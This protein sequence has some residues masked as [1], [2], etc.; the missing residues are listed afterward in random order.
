MSA[1]RENRKRRNERIQ[2]GL[3][4]LVMFSLVA[5]GVV[6]Y[7]MY[8]QR[9]AAEAVIYERNE[10][11]ESVPVYAE[12]PSDL[13]GLGDSELAFRS[14][15]AA[16]DDWQV[17]EDGTVIYQ[18]KH[19]RRASF[20]KATLAVGVDRKDG[21][22]TGNDPL[23]SGQ[24]DVDMIIAQDTAHNRIRILMIPRNAIVSMRVSDD[25]GI[26][27]EGTAYDQ[28]C[29][30]YA[31]GD[32]GET[33]VQNTLDAVTWTLCGTKLDYYAFTDMGILGRVNDAVGGVTVTIPN[34]ELVKANPEW[35]KGRTVTLMG[36]EAERFIR[37]RDT[38]A[39]NTAL[40][41]MQ[42]H[43]EYMVGFYDTLRAQ[44]R[45]DSSIVTELYDLISGDLISDLQKAE[46]LKLAMDGL[47]TGSLSGEDIITLPGASIAADE[48][49]PWDRVFI[50]YTSAIPMILDMFYR[51]I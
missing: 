51:E 1:E 33:S 39:D 37:Y 22:G 4:S 35:T 26:W 8:Q 45:K 14:L 30:A 25:N 28:L 16:R 41:R 42:Q 36:S 32:G 38:D 44:A 27:Q 2:R 43:R 18:G 5:G 21:L 17:Q 7:S 6:T 46:F 31:H 19:Y 29:L 11:A 34:D 24:N 49:Y 50:D 23:H 48:T 13:E 3:V 10:Q 12:E 9:K 20:I 40:Y 15:I 47:N